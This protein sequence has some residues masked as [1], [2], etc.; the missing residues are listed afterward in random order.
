M[1]PEPVWKFWRWK[2]DTR[3]PDRSARSVTCITTA[4]FRASHEI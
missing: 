4:L 3:S 2:E 1:T